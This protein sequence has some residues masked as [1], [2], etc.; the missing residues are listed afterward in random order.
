MK[1]IRPIA[2]SQATSS[3]NIS[4]LHWRRKN[5]RHCWLFFYQSLPRDQWLRFMLHLLGARSDNVELSSSCNTSL[6]I[7]ALFLKS[8]LSEKSSSSPWQRLAYTTQT[9]IHETNNP[10]HKY[11]SAFRYPT[12]APSYLSC[13]GGTYIFMQL[14][15]ITYLPLPVEASVK[16]VALTSWVPLMLVLAPPYCN[17]SLCL[18]V[19]DQEG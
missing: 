7:L 8:P 5:G 19:V 2:K 18:F 10:C 6:L 9:G 13:E 4:S 17:N 1:W 12:V 3:Q 14:M 15:C 11:T 16:T